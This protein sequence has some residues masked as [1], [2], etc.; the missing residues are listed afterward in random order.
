V[1][2]AFRAFPDDSEAISWRS[3]RISEKWQIMTAFN[4]VR[5]KVKAGREQQFLDAH[6]KVAFAWPGLRHVNI[7]KTREHTFCVITEWTDM[8]RSRGA[9]AMASAKWP[10]GQRVLPRP[11]SDRRV[12]VLEYSSGSGSPARSVTPPGIL[13]NRNAPGL[14]DAFE[15]CCNVDAV[16]E[17][18]AFF[19]NDVADVDADADIDSLVADRRNF[20]KV[21]LW[22]KD[23]RHVEQLLFAGN[24]LDKARAL[25]AAYAK[26]RPR[27]RLT[28]RQ[29][30]RVVAE[31]PP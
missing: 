31:W 22:T 17:D 26:T 18:V 24:N 28:I 9:Q 2:R 25:F 4:A 15:A 13:G 7:I 3:R 14:C 6:N 27:A 16:A 5:F 19:D 20:F 30:S 23:S 11:L 12:P 1:H 21:E 8:P 10:A 29:R